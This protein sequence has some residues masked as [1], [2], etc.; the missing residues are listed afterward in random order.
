MR[1][2]SPHAAR[3][4]DPHRQ[5]DSR[6]HCRCP[7]GNSSPACLPRPL[8]EPMQAGRP[9]SVRV[10]VACA[11][12]QGCRTARQR[13]GLHALRPARSVKGCTHNARSAGGS[14]PGQSGGTCER[15][16]VPPPPR[17]ALSPPDNRVPAPACLVRPQASHRPSCLLAPGSLALSPVPAPPHS[18]S[19][20]GRACRAWSRPGE[21][22]AQK[23]L[24]A[25]DLRRDHDGRSVRLDWRPTRPA[26]PR[27][28]GPPANR[29]ATGRRPLGIHPVLPHLALLSLPSTQPTAWS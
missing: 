23:L 29:G 26:L 16:Q 4:P 18:E 10:L 1:G 9:R 14:V 25:S 12:L 24:A 28:H 20:P 8:P 2:S 7:M 19:A 15:R 13:Q 3:S 21:E 17:Q 5:A 22:A 27:R 6:K 11:L